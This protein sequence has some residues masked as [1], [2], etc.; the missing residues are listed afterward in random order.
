M[1]GVVWQKPRVDSLR[2]LDVVLT[3]ACNSNCT[4]CYQNARGNC[5]MDWGTLRAGLDLLLQS[6]EEVPSLTFYGGEPLLELPLIKRAIRYI[7]STRSHGKKI[8]LHIITNGLLLNR[9]TI[10]FLARHRVETQI[11]FDGVEAAQNLR[12]P[13]TFDR[14]DRLLVELRESD[15]HFFNDLCSF[16][17]T[18]SS[19]NVCHLAESFA[20]FLE[21]GA[22][23]IAVS[24]VVTHDPGWRLDSIEALAGQVAA[25][26]QMSHNLYR[27]TGETAFA[28][29]QNDTPNAPPGN[30]HGAMCGA[31]N[32]DELAVAVDG[33]F[34]RC[35]MLIGSY[36]TFPNGVLSRELDHLRLGNL[37][38]P[39]LG[40]R[41]DQH[42]AAVRA[43][44]IFDNKQDKY[45]SYR[46]CDGCRFLHQ[47]S[48]CP[49]SI[50]HIPG[51]TDPNRVPDIQCA[52]N[53]AL[54]AARESFFE[55]VQPA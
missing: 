22:R 47:C 33:Q 28:P 46:T 19:R 42:A 14:L 32:T 17:I 51:N 27:L 35:V 7:Q 6:E 34:S 40:R 2:A 36:Q 21:R 18:V 44:G 23:N 11:S 53:L 49:I 9:D 12:A 39:E 1:T 16:A 30:S 10:A 13:G 37:R 31:Q 50:C 4:Y 54:L 38:D 29:F 48:I 3:T 52:T 8:A 5:S 41:L 26:L 20:Y 55:Q 45:S 24:P 43:I 15:E 25:V